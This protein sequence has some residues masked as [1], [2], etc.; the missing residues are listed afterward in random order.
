[1]GSSGNPEVGSGGNPEVGSGGNPEVG[2]GGNPEV[3]S[4]GNPEVG[5]GGPGFGGIM[6]ILLGSMAGSGRSGPSMPFR[7]ETQEVSNWCWAAVS[8]AV[9]RYYNPSSFLRQCEVAAGMVG[10]QNACIDPDNNNEPGALQ[11]ALEIIG[12]GDEHVVGP[13]KFDRLQAEIDAGRP[14]CVRIEWEGGGAH[15]AVLCGYKEYSDL[16]DGVTALTTVDVA[17]PFYPDST[18]E[19]SDSV[20]FFESYHGRG[21]WS[22]TYLTN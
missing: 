2:S 19:F 20:N 9:D 4:G 8:S 12:R 18:R 14:V 1:V 11:T 7:V 5:S 21:T 22:H 3:G 16:T 17:D 13:I 6:A 15:F 10:M